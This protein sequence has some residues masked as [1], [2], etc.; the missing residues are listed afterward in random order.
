MLFGQ[1]A[2]DYANQYPFAKLERFFVE[3][4]EDE[5]ENWH[6]YGEWNEITP[7]SIGDYIQVATYL[8]VTGSIPTIMALTKEI[9]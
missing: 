6:D 4:P 1:E 9:P 8:L 2:I 7:N 5:K 3:E